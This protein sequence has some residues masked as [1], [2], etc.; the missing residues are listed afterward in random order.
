MTRAIGCG[1]KKTPQGASSEPS[2]GDD[3]SG[4]PGLNFGDGWLESAPP[5]VDSPKKAIETPLTEAKFLALSLARYRAREALSNRPGIKGQVRS[6]TQKV[7]STEKRSIRAAIKSG[8]TFADLMESAERRMDL[9]YSQKSFDFSNPESFWRPRCI[10]YSL[11]LDA[12]IKTWEQ[13]RDFVERR[14]GYR[15][16]GAIK[17]ASDEDCSDILARIED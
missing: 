8:Y 7:S 6:F 11:E 2:A 16:K 5:A 1:G 13:H 10:S 9:E 3:S 4:S 14:S 12:G 17:I 15:N